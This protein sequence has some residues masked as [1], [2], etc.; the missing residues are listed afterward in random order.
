MTYR[1]VRIVTG[2]AV[3]TSTPGFAALTKIVNVTDGIMVARIDATASCSGA[4]V[5]LAPPTFAFPLAMFPVAG[6]PASGLAYAAHGTTFGVG[7]GPDIAYTG[8]SYVG[9]VNAIQLIGAAPGVAGMFLDFGALCPP[10]LFHFRFTHVAPAIVIG[11]IAH[12]GFLLTLPA[13][14]PAATPVGVEIMF[15]WFNNPTAAGLPW[16]STPAMG[17]RCLV[18]VVQRRSVPR[19]NP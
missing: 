19:G 13:A 14:I 18:S 7:S 12:G 1:T 9:S 10:P 4:G 6:G 17:D 16:E 15:Q 3:D 8:H 11:P 2:L 5:F